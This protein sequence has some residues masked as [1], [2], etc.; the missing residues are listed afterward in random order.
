MPPES[1]L[2][3]EKQI[4]GCMLLLRLAARGYINPLQHNPLND[5]PSVSRSL[6]G[7]AGNQYFQTHVYEK[8]SQTLKCPSR[9]SL[10]YVNELFYG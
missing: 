10:K 7:S 4:Q 8:R 5:P 9:G 1:A 6:C 2:E 3:S